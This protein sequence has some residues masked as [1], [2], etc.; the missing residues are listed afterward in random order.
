MSR[1]WKIQVAK[2][3]RTQ[4]DRL[5]LSV[6]QR[7]IKRRLDLAC[8]VRLN[9]SIESW[10]KFKIHCFLQVNDTNANTNNSVEQLSKQY[11][12]LLKIVLKPDVWPHCELKLA[13]F[14]RVLL[15]TELTQSAQP[16]AIQ[17]QPSYAKFT[18]PSSCSPSR[19]VC[20]ERT[21]FLLNS[22]R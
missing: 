14:E 8:Q 20:W 16:G 21:R 22:S 4:G 6:D 2:F 12:A 9:F 17:S 11:I 13:W 1:A 10:R 5:E 18:R 19:M 7:I 3:H 15:V